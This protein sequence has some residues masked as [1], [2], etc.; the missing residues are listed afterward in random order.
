M[1][2]DFLRRNAENKVADAIKLFELGSFSNA[3]YLGGYGLEIALK[4]CIA[5]QI[6]ADTIPDKKFINDV[7]VHDI[8]RL[9]RLAGLS[10]PLQQAQD[11]DFEFGQRWG[12]VCQWSPDSRY[13]S[14]D[15]YN[16]N[17]FLDAIVNDHHG[18]MPWIK[19]HW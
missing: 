17:V 7:Y 11:T 12:I 3:Y 13:L 19:R 2:I 5:R 16:C 14:T 8:Q 9:V 10:F 6:S 1:H 18:V 4:A 15:Q